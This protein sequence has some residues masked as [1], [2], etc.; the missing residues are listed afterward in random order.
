MTPTRHSTVSAGFT[1]VSTPLCT[2][3][4]DRIDYPCFH[5]LPVSP[6]D[7]IALPTYDHKLSRPGLLQSGRSVGT[8]SRARRETHRLSMGSCWSL[9]NPAVCV[10]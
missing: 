3:A 4:F 6:R 10:R 5:S 7:A 1:A 8:C 9:T 2:I